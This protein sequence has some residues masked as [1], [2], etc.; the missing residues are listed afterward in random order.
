MHG[1][2]DAAAHKWLADTEHA[3]LSVYLSIARLSSRFRRRFRLLH[4]R[5][6]GTRQ[7]VP[8][9]SDPQALHESCVCTLTRQEVGLFHF[10]LSLGYW[11]SLQRVGLEARHARGRGGSPAPSKGKKKQCNEWIRLIAFTNLLYNST[12]KRVI[13]NKLISIYNFAK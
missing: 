11:A 13:I 4:G 8:A 10:Q 2:G 12:K 9:K 7:Y 1:G 6:G 5:V 3:R